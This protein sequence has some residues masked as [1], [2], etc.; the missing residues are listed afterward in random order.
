VEAQVDEYDFGARG[1]GLERNE[2]FTVESKT[3]YLSGDEEQ[4][5]QCIS[6]RA[7]LPEVLNGICSALAC[8]IGNV[9][10]LIAMPT[11][12]ASDLA[13]IA[14]NAAQFGLHIFYSESV[15]AG[16][17]EQLGTFE[18]YS[19][20]PRSPSEG[21]CRL[22][23]RAKGLAVLALKVDRA[24]GHPGGRG[25]AEEGPLRGNALEKPVSMN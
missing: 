7:P 20:V 6:S 21:E 22:I 5:L 12:D 19:S 13:A 17:G 9:V 25:K 1:T 23:E 14:M 8:Q 24:P 18:V 2:P 11:D 3:H 16:D 15:V 10:S 4:L